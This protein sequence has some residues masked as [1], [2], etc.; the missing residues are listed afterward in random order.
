VPLVQR[1]D[2]LTIK[3]G[4]AHIWSAV[5]L[6][7]RHRRPRNLSIG[8][9]SVVERVHISTAQLLQ[10]RSVFANVLQPAVPGD[11]A[12]G[13]G[14]ASRA[15]GNAH[16]CPLGTLPIR[17]TLIWT[18]GIAV[19]TILTA[20]GLQSLMVFGWWQDWLGVWQLLGFQERGLD[21][22][23][24]VDRDEAISGDQIVLAASGRPMSRMD[25]GS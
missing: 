11:T 24:D 5:R 14:R 25:S 7:L 8:S 12:D 3:L 9:K 16:G 21:I 6:P 1:S 10:R 23:R 18:A 22:G 15:L 2:V 19:K 4:T 17:Q 13:P 20:R